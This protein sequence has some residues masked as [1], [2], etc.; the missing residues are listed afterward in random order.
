[1]SSLLWFRE[2]QTSKLSSRHRAGG[3][4]GAEGCGRATREG[5]VMMYLIQEH[6]CPITL[7]Q[8]VHVPKNCLYIKLDGKNEGVS[9]CSRN[10]VQSI[11]K[12]LTE[13]NL[14]VCHE[15]F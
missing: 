15:E 10:Q 8:G 1:M 11:E 3:R 4:E 2:S 5:F 6:I 9:A 7:Y 13:S 12:A 14:K